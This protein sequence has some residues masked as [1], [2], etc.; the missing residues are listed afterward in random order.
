MYVGLPLDAKT[1]LN[2]SKSIHKNHKKIIFIYGGSQGAINLI[3]NFLLMINKFDNI[4]L[5]KFK[6]VIQS[7]KQL[8]SDLEQ[9]L[10]KLKI[11]YIIKD[12][13]NNMNEILSITDIAITR[14]GA[15]TINDLIRYR[16]PSIIFPLPDSIQNHQF[17]NAKYLADKKGAILMDE[18]N[19]NVDINSTILNKLINNIAKQQLMK[20]ALNEIIIP[21]ANQL[22]LKK[23]LYEN[24]K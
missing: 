4:F 23:I 20:K 12:F 7:P 17:F 3:K 18:N 6:L 16:I 5:E 14:A 15:G 2:F 8:L 22:M 10:N 19:F 1:E 11:D 24:K 21:D 9:S 13:F